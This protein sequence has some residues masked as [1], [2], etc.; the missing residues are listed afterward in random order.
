MKESRFTRENFCFFFV[1]N[2]RFIFK[3]EICI[4]SIEFDFCF[5]IE[6]DFCSSFCDLIDDREKLNEN[7]KWKNEKQFDNKKKIC[8]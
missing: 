3:F 5:F 4:F 8:K 7:A 2:F 6:S 1:L